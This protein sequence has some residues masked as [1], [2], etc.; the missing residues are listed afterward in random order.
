MQVFDSLLLPILSYAREVWGVDGKVS[1][2]DQSVTQHSARHPTTAPCTH[3][4]YSNS[5]AGGLLFGVNRTAC[6]QARLGI[7]ALLSLL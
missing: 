2:A 6:N 5:F 7:L 1:D 4:R 3:V